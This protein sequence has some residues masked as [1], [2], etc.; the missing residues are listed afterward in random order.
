MS[1][2]KTHNLQ[3]P[4]AASVNIALAPNNGVV[5]AGIS[6]F[7]NRVLIGTNIEGHTDADDLTIGSSTNT[8]GITIR[9]NTSGTG[10]LWF[11]DGTS[12]AAEYQGYV[13]YDHNNQRLSLGSG[14]TTKLH[15]LSSGDLSFTTTTQ[16]AFLGLKADSTA[17]NLT[18]GSTTGTHPR[19]YFYGTGNGQSTAGDIFMGTGTGGDLRLRSGGA[20]KLQTN[21]DNSTIDAFFIH[22]A[23]T[24][25]VNTFIPD[26]T[27]RLDVAGA[28]QFTTSTTNQQNDFLTGQLTVRNNQSAQGAFIDFRA[29][30]ANGTQGVI[31]KIGGFNT[32]SGSGYDGLLTFS[33]RQTSNNTMVER[34]RITSDGKMGIKTSTPIG[35]LD[36]YDGTFVLS[37][38]NASGNERNWRFVNNNV[39][40]GNLG[41]QVST[42]AGGS[43]FANLVEITKNGHIGINEG[44]PDRRLHLK[45][46]GQIKLENTSTGGWAGLDF[47]VSS[48]TNN[49]DAY[50]GMQDSDGI[51]FIDNNSNGHDFRIDRDGRVTTPNTPSFAAFQSQSVWTVSGTMVFNSTRHNVGN[52]YSTSNGHFTAPV[53]GSYQFNFYSIY[54]G[55][56]TS[57]W[58]SMY[59]N[60][61]RMVGGDIHFTYYDL[62][63]NWDSVSFSQVIYLSQNDYIEMKSAQSTDWH[64]NN[65]QCFSGY[66]LG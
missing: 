16:N 19:A 10:R 47:I 57:G 66:L 40:A 18:L 37:K 62:G 4:D 52:H 25:A 26:T 63:N 21:S 33:T 13:Q 20:I 14:G 39:A 56:H 32:H 54:R 60:N 31:A 23:G 36:V 27:Y 2:L 24:V 7:N 45:D 29:D 58:V 50:M 38:P 46:S 9:T 35:T 59:K 3:S 41:L 17:I 42:A 53:S 65:W 22:A 12:G 15:I 30:S 43:T 8:A 49:Y 5:V 48:G 6:T 44:T 64:G 11:S 51:F 55:N 61:A 28:G 1:T 34:M